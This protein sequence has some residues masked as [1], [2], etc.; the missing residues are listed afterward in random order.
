MKPFILYE[1]S[2]SKDLPRRIAEGDPSASLGMMLLLLF[3]FLFPSI[4]SASSFD[5]THFASLPILH[6]GRVKPLETVAR[7]YFKEGD[8]VD[9]LAQA[10]F[11]PQAVK[12]KPLFA[13]RSPRLQQILKLDEVSGDRYTYQQLAPRFDAI[14][15]ALQQIAAKEPEM[16]TAYE[17]NLWQLYGRVDAFAQ[18]LRSFNAYLPLYEGLSEGLQK[19][20]EIKSEE[21]SYAQ[22]KPYRREVDKALKRILK[23]KGEDISSYNEKE[24]EIATLSFGL[25][26]QHLIGKQNTLFRVLPMLDTPTGQ[27]W[28]S[29]WAVIEQGKGAPHLV[30]LLQQWQFLARAYR[31]GDM[32]DWKHVSEDLKNRTLAHSATSEWRLNLEQIYHQAMLIPLAVLFYLLCLLAL[33]FRPNAAWGMFWAGVTANGLIVMTRMILLERPP[34]SNLY[35]SILFVALTAA[36]FIYWV[37]YRKAPKMALALGASLGGGLLIAS[38][39][40]AGEGDTME[41]LIAVLNT[42]FWLA[43]HVIII[44]LGY[45]VSLVAGCLG[46]VALMKEEWRAKVKSFLL[47]VT[48]SALLLTTVGTILGGIWADQSWGR[49]WGWDPKENGA[50]LIVLWLVWLLH[51]KIAGMSSRSGFLA[52]LALTNVIVAL[53][54]FGVNL[55]NTGLHSYGF[56]DAAAYGLVG[57]CVV[58]L[59]LISWLYMRSRH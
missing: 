40:Y 37:G 9:Q 6:E 53:S 28:V 27:E 35:E 30:P 34:V 45:A 14:R 22:L 4:A 54:W 2:K 16:L 43:T 33:R 18:L 23:R 17:K 20:F 7:I 41:V 50:L 31:A 29:P 26:E 19:R 42:N 11:T 15:P 10:L 57:F 56:T 36:L 5:H 38:G 24:L 48:V 32:A 44:T 51:G 25:M 49:F 12:Q 52:M 58:E 47:P 3:F 8:A 46:H 39:A 13:V 1:Q 55:L 21:Q 59:V